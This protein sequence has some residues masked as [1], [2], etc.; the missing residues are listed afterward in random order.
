MIDSDQAAL[1]ADACHADPP[2]YIAAGPDLWNKSGKGPRGQ[3]T[4]ETYEQVWRERGFSTRLKMADNNRLLGWRRMREWLKPYPAPNGESTTA[5]LQIIEGRS[6]N[7]IRTLPHLIHDE[8]KP[9]DVKADGEDHAGDCLRYG[10]MSRPAPKQP[11][12]EIPPSDFDAR[13]AFK[14]VEERRKRMRYIGHERELM[15]VYGRNRR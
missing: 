7:L 9:E 8:G 15:E 4:A 5:R 14:M 1:I 3:S 13:A 2:E 11:P 12:K 6:P 10:L